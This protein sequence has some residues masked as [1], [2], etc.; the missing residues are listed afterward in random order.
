MLHSGILQPNE[1]HEIG[2]GGHGQFFILACDKEYLDVKF[3]GTFPDI[4]RMYKGVPAQLN[5]KNAIIKNPH[6][7]A[8]SY[9]IYCAPIGMLFQEGR[10]IEAGAT[11]IIGSVGTI[12]QPLTDQGGSISPL[13]ANS[14]GVT[15]SANQMLVA[16]VDNPSGIIV[17]SCMF[18]PTTAGTASLNTSDGVTRKFFGYSKNNEYIAAREFFVAANRTLEIHISGNYSCYVT[19][20]IL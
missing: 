13:G 20:D 1:V 19:Y 17:R 14:F 18:I 16:A 4:L 6:S 2:N 3:G 10:N 9:Q 5:F 11:S 15:I 8:I 7:V 12:G